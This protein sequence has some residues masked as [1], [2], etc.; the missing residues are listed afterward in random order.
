MSRRLHAITLLVVAACTPARRRTPDD[1]LVVAI[2][3]PMTTFDPRYSLTNLDAKLVK[4]VATGLTTV[5]TPNAEARLELAAAIDRVDDVTVDVTLRADARFS[6]GSPVTADD[7]I[8]TY[9]TVVD[10][11]CGSLYLKG[12]AERYASLEARGDKVVRF[13][14]VQPLGTFVT[15]IEFSVISFHGVPAGECRPPV[16]GAGPYVVRELTSRHVVLDRNPYYRE[17][18][19]LPHV[20]IEFVR[21]DSARILMLVGGSVDLV[22]NGVRPDL[23]DD[24]VGQPRVAMHAGP[25]VLLTYL[26]LNNTSKWLDDVRVREA[27]ALAIDRPAIVTA[28]FGGRAVLATGLLP[29]SHW[30]YSAEVPHWDHDPARA[31]AL[32]DEAGLRPD[33][34]GIRLRLVYKTSSVDFRVAIARLIASQLR[35]VGIAVEVKPFEFGTFFR[36]I[37]QGNYELASM[38]SSEI[39]EP[40]F[41]YFYFDSS[42]IPSEQDLDGGNRWRYRNP[43]LDRIVEAARREM[44]PARRKPLY[45]EAQRIVARDLPIVPLWHEDNVVLSNVDVQGYEIV[46]NARFVGLAAATKYQH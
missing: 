25:S 23:V 24:V 35:E 22:Q 2:E 38:Q 9:R 36:D 31:R 4:L 8:R 33:A 40:D 20:E 6:D 3:T 27:I 17:P 12:F 41:Y 16:I 11:A 5:D 39:T 44:D 28:K 26:L 43:E 15:D 32:L 1:T 37:K 18:A 34:D 7:V 14:L 30:A 21:D 42:R 13:H 10:P 29:P 19:R 45:A 46:P